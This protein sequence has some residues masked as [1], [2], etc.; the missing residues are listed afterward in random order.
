MNDNQSTTTIKATTSKKTT[1]FFGT[2]NTNVPNG[3]FCFCN[4]E[5]RAVFEALQQNQF[6]AEK[7]G[8]RG[9]YFFCSVEVVKQQ[10]AQ[11]LPNL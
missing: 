10:H 9:F 11:F 5:A 4:P 1:R 8:F 7:S 3:V 6:A 2:K